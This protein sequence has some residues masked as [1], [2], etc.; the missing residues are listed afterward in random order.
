MET[1]KGNVGRRPHRHC[2]NLTSDQTKV[3]TLLNRIPEQFGGSPGKLNF[4]VRPGYCADDLFNAILHFQQTQV[5]TLYKADGIV[6][7]GGATFVYMNRL[8]D[9]YMPVKKV[10]FATEDKMNQV[11]LDEKIK[12]YQERATAKAPE[13]THK[14]AM[15]HLEAQKKW[16]AWKDAIRRDGRGSL[17]AKLAIQ[18]LDDEERKSNADTIV[19]FFPWAVGFGDAFIGYDYGS[20]WSHEIMLSN[21]LLDAYDKRKLIVNTH[22]VKNNPAVIVFGNFTYY[23]MKKDEVV[24]FTRPINY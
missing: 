19:P 24:E 13:Y 20:D 12:I 3:M 21:T 6:E 15:E 14:V 7:P 10:D 5:L 1:L 2:L 23:V 17:S 18:Y 16:K 9:L 11:A 22:G 8:A 4:I